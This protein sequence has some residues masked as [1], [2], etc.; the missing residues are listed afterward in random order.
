ASEFYRAYRFYNRGQQEKYRSQQLPR[1]VSD[2]PPPLQRPSFDVHEV[3]AALGDH[4]AILRRLGLILDCVMTGVDVATLSAFSQ[5]KIDVLSASGAPSPTDQ[6]P[7][8]SY[9]PANFV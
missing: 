8:T 9:D 6:S 1:V 4:P 2:I 5:I 3:L 7:W